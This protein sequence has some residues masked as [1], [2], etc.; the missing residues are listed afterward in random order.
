M[1]VTVPAAPATPQCE[2]KDPASSAGPEIEGF[3]AL[4]K[5]A[6]KV[7][8]HGLS[9]R[10]KKARLLAFLR[11]GDKLIGVAG[12]KHPARTYR[13]KVATKSA[14]DLTEE[15]FPFEL[16]WVSVLPD[17]QGGK[18]KLLC[19]PLLREVADAGVFATTGTN[20]VRMQ[21]TLSKLGFK[22]VGKEWPSAEG[23]ETLC[24]FTLTRVKQSRRP[25]GLGDPSQ[26]LQ[27]SAESG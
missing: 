4:V 22:K 21:V 23:D 7:A 17:A 19:E 1:G 24:L 11:E 6:G 8:G 2:V 14:I 16:G 26:P 20:N 9:G 25:S 10:I 3:V 15:L 18:S 12:L 13:G 27:G 5:S